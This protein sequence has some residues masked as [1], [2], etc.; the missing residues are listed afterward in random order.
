MALLPLDPERLEF[1]L[2]WVS[3]EPVSKEGDDSC[4]EH[5][6]NFQRVGIRGVA[7]LERAVEASLFEGCPKDIPSLKGL[8]ATPPQWPVSTSGHGISST[9]VIKRARCLAEDSWDR[10]LV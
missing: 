2:L 6:F 4:A 8:G 7:D 5:L 1:S 3:L 9:V 10:I